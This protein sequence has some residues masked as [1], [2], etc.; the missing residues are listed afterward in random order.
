[1]DT[2]AV[3]RS[4]TGRR[5]SPFARFRRRRPLGA[6]AAAVLL[7]TPALALLNVGAAGG[8]AN[9]A[10]Q[11]QW[12]QGEAIT[13]NFWGPLALAHDGQNEPYVEAP[14]GSRLVQYFD[15]A[16]MELTNPTTGVVTNGLLANELIT[17][18]LQVGDAT[19]QQLPPAAISIAGDPNNLGPTYAQLGTTASALLAPATAK[20]GGFIT[21]IVG[22]DGA[23]TDGGGF[24]GISMSPAISAY[25]G[26]TQHNV[27][28]AFADFRNTVGL[29]SVG[30][31]TSEPFRT[32]VKIAG[33]PQSIIAQVF[34]RRVLTYNDNN[35]DPFKV[36]FGN[37]GQ[38]Y[39]TWRSVTNAGGG[40]SVATGT[41]TSTPTT[42]T[43]TPTTTPPT[44]PVLTHPSV[45]NVTGTRVTVSFT[46][47]VAACGTAEIRVKGDTSFTTNIDSITCTPTTSI[48]VTLTS[49][50][51]NTPYEVRGAAK[52]GAG[53]VGY[54]DLASF[55]TLSAQ[56]TADSY[57][58]NWLN[59]APGTTGVARLTIDVT[60]TALAI[61]V[62]DRCNSS[63]SGCIV[64]S[65][66]AT[67][68][69]DPVVGK[70][71]GETL[72]ISFTDDTRTHLKV[73]EVRGFNPTITTTTYTFRRR[74]IFP[75]GPITL[76]PV[77]L[78]P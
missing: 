22:A 45:T 14:G 28:G 43:T 59:D 6:L 38:H 78:K 5:S 34:E 24:A 7:L 12:Q 47:D 53:P 39:Y 1:M 46:T 23:V 65:G 72:T 68:S 63:P 20:I 30:L 52:V 54:S 32:T 62:Y 64:V 70:L 41:A 2:H 57:D 15:K 11:T 71:T 56:A 3:S 16:R 25:D 77:A 21:T 48:T 66:V 49:L 13:P 10:F 40:T 44:A 29:A 73:V 61:S 18:K 17:G 26:T 37:I 60:G 58:G 9:P 35:A 4:P 8:F 75:V 27:L 33:T 51:P 19:F 67:F 50:N 55:T 42:P 76:P 36:E 31:A 74:V 69:G